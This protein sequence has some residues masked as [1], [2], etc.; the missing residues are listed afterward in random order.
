MSLKQKIRNFSD[1]DWKRVLGLP[2]RVDDKKRIDHS[3]AQKGWL[4]GKFGFPKEDLEKAS[5]ANLESE[6]HDLVAKECHGFRF[7]MQAWE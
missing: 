7:E 5:S 3:F 6:R 1:A 2:R 4:Y